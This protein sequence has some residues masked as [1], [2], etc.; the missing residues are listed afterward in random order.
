VTLTIRDQG[1]GIPEE[2]LPRISELMFTTKQETGG[3]GLGL[4]I[5]DTI[6]K[7]HRGTLSFAS[8]TGSGT[9]V[10]VTFPVEESK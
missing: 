3:I 10:V 2:D 6:V 5:T 8:V 1:C 9:E 7:E 4:Y